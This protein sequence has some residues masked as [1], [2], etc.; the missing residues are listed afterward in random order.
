VKQLFKDIRQMGQLLA[1]TAILKSIYLGKEVDNTT[2][3]RMLDAKISGAIHVHHDAIATTHT[4]NVYYDYV[5]KTN[6]TN[7]LLK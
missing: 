6:I 1:Y 7:Q 3:S 5:N 2:L 4:L